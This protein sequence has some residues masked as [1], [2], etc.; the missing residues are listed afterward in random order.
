MMWTFNGAKTLPVVLDRINKVIPEENVR[1]KLVVDDHST[2]N[3][4]NI[5][6][7]HGWVVTFND[8]KGIS[9]G[10]NTALKYVETKYF[11]SFEQDLYLASDWWKKVLGN[12]L[13]REV[14]AASGIRV[15]YPSE[16]MRQLHLYSAM[17][18]VNWL[19]GLP[20]YLDTGKRVEVAMG[21]GRTLDNTVYDTEVLRSVGGFPRLNVHGGVDTVLT[22]RLVSAGYE[23]PVNF[24][25][26]SL[27]LN[28]S[29]VNMLRCQY[30]YGTC[31]DEI[32]VHVPGLP[33]NLSS[34]TLRFFYSPFAALYPAFS[35]R[36]PS[37]FVAYPLMRLQVLRGLLDGRRGKRWSKK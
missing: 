30:N 28:K 35:R 20:V 9:D 14:A 7:E 18:Y 17:R 26:V 31:Y 34:Q 11:C 12:V 3:T 2:D 24:D 25:V 33:V 13:K 21:W 27:H 10:A 8:G 37:I 5:A 36:C 22:Y 23:W 6:V 19:R 32:A 29:F 16:C 4:R 1:L 15:P